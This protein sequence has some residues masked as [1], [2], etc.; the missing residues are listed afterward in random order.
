MP[1]AYRPKGATPL[2]KALKFVVDANS[3]I[4]S[5]ERK[6]G[7]VREAAVATNI[8]NRAAD[9]MNKWGCPRGAQ[10][11]KRIDKIWRGP[12]PR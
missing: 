2:C 9:D 7:N 6:K 8:A 3:D 4:A 12:G 5:E 10:A 1:Q 11:R